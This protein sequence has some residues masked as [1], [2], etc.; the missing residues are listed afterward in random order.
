M[1][2]SIHSIGIDVKRLNLHGYIIFGFRLPH[3]DLNERC[4]IRSQV[5]AE[6]SY[7]RVVL[8]AR[9]H[10]IIVELS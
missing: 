4:N 8:T 10:W 2:P 9:R 7:R 1:A 6:A 5:W 3:K